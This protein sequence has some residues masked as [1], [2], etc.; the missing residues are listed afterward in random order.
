ME[1][2]RVA[3]V[4][5]CYDDGETLGEAL[6]SLRDQEP[7]EL[8]VVDDGSSDPAT[9]AVLNALERDGVRVSVRRTRACRRHG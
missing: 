8:V 7:H 9:L 6:D 3:V 2:A 4:V 5:P 1:D